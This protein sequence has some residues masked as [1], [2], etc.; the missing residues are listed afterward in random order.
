MSSTL[1]VALVFACSSNEG[2]GSLGG[3]AGGT[4][5]SGG[6]SADASADA[7][8]RDGS[9]LLDGSTQDGST[10]GSPNDGGTLD[11]A[12]D[13]GDGGAIEDAGDSGTIE[14]SGTDG[15]EV[16]V[17]ADAGPPSSRHVERPLGT[18][19]AGN[20]YWEYLPP[21]YDLVSSAPLLVFWHGVGENGNGTTDLPN[22]TRNGPPKLIKNDTWPNT[23]PFIVLSP[24]N[25]TGGSCPSAASVDAFITFAKATYRVDPKRIYLTGLSCGAI[26][27]W[28]Y[29]RAHRGKDVAAALLI[30]GNPG[31]IW[32]TVGC[33]LVDEI[34]LWSVHGDPDP[35]VPFEPDRAAM[36]S[37][38]QCPQPRRD[39]RWT[40]VENGGHDTWTKTYDGDYGDVYQWLLDNP[41]P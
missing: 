7:A 4:S 32:S 28:N 3:G 35:T 9:A 6:T 36:E 29:L 39:V 8:Q 24:Q 30:A 12:T 10:G 37:F 21:T 18:T 31:N 20:G 26:G 23:R 1:G 41:K 15:G 13:A 38:L 14:D 16:E 25:Q 2:G 33:A 19:E 17:P 22:V 34:A 11:A 5:G 40:P 27:S